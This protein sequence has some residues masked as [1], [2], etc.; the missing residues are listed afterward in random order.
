MDWSNQYGN[1]C[2]VGDRVA[3]NPI[4]KRF[5]AP[6]RDVDGFWLG[7]RIFGL[8]CSVP[9]DKPIDQVRRSRSDSWSLLF[10]AAL[11]HP[12]VPFGFA[13]GS[14]SA[15]VCVAWE[16]R[17]PSPDC[18]AGLS[19]LALCLGHWRDR[20]LDDLALL[21]ALAPLGGKEFGVS[22]RPIVDGFVETLDIDLAERLVQCSGEQFAV[23][24]GSFCLKVQD[25]E[26][27]NRFDN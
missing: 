9:F 1:Q 2:G 18:Q 23:G 6:H 14:T 22:D 20:L 24:D 26:L 21:P 15:V 16:I 12:F 5:V 3:C 27:V 19:S 8:L 13:D 17:S 4:W 10:C 25:K 11:A 7:C